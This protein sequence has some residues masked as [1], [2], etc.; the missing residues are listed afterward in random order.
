MVKI[1]LTDKERDKE[2]HNLKFKEV[3]YK[4]LLKDCDPLFKQVIQDAIIGVRYKLTQLN[5]DTKLEGIADI[6]DKDVFI[7]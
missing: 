2:I 3:Y 1:I 4:K 6:I 5:G 7:V